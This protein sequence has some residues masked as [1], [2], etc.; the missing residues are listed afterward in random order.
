MAK[1]KFTEDLIYSQ[2]F[3]FEVLDYFDSI[4]TNENFEWIEK[5]F[6]V[7]IK[8]ENKTAEKFN[9]HHIRP[10]CT[11]KDENHKNRKQTQKLGDEFNGNIIKLSIYNHIFAHFYLWK[12]FNTLDLKISFQRMC[13][14]GKYVDNFTEDELDEI[15]RLKE[16]CAKKNQTEEEK[17]EYKKIYSKKWREEHPDYNQKEEIKEYK[18]NWSIDNRDRLKEKQKNQPKTEEQKIAKRLYFKNYYETHKN[19]E[20]FKKSQKRQ[21][22]KESSKIKAREYSRNYSKTH[23]QEK[24]KYIINNRD[25]INKYRRTYTQEHREELLEKRRSYE[26]QMCFDPIAQNKCTVRALIGR[27]HNHKELYKDVIVKNC[28]IQT[29]VPS[30]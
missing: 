20:N 25:K 1:Y 5:Y 29:S 21:K 2:V 19:D 6:N 11:F 27:K 3:S 30:T 8:D 18:R 16:E 17:K 15:A 26:R 13:G 24:R 14:E 22:E 28:I 7:L 10:C 4:T 12:I 9:T 23:K